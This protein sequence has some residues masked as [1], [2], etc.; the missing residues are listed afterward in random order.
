MV[1][2]LIDVGSQWG[3]SGIEQIQKCLFRIRHLMRCFV[4][5][6]C[7]LSGLLEGFCSCYALSMKGKHLLLSEVS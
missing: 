4:L 1:F 5:P 6:S 2:Q 7:L 3:K